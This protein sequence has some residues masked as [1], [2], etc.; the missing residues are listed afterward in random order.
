M[1]ELDSTDRSSKADF[2]LRITFNS[3]GGETGKLIFPLA[4]DL[5]TAARSI[6]MGRPVTSASST[7]TAA[8]LGPTTSLV[9]LVATTAGLARSAAATAVEGKNVFIMDVI[10]AN[11]LSDAQL[12]GWGICRWLGYLGSCDNSLA[13]RCR[14]MCLWC[15][16]VWAL[17]G[18][19]RV[20][21]QFRLCPLSSLW[22]LLSSASSTS[23]WYWPGLVRDFEEPF[24]RIPEKEVLVFFPA[25]DGRVGSE[26]VR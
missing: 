17:W 6:T 11:I 5:V 15:V 16:C 7:V 3:P 24:G 19:C 4:K 26:A 9:S 18:L 21:L 12:P 25:V 1:V 23:K 20:L 22:M 2:G 8:T 14:L 10:D 13:A